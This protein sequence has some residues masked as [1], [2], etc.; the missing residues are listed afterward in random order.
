MKALRCLLCLGLLSGLSVLSHAAKT[1]SYVV[2]GYYDGAKPAPELVEKAAKAVGERMGAMQP[3]ADP[4]AADHVVEVLFL[5]DSF[6]IYVDALPL[7]RKPLR[8]VMEHGIADLRIKAD[9]AHEQAEGH[10]LPR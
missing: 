10:G 6:K 7:E 9:M 3:A 4:D 5:R 2:T 8:T 1:E